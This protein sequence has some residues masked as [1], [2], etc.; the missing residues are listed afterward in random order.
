MGSEPAT[1]TPITAAASPSGGPARGEVDDTTQAAGLGD[2][3]F[4]ALEL[5]VGD[6]G[7]PG[8]GVARGAVDGVGGADGDGVGSGVVDGVGDG[9]G[10]G[11]GD[12]E[13]EGLGDA[14][15]TIE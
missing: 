14:G 8:G 5:G 10:E 4:V 13:G 9:D 7:G 15:A 1:T 3:G 6:G 12:G 2:D 11:L